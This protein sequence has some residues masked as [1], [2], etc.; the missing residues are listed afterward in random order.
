[1]YR[2]NTGD[3]SGSYF[4]RPLRAKA[5]VGA[6]TRFFD[7]L[8]VWLDRTR[9][10]KLLVSPAGSGTPQSHGGLASRYH[11]GRRA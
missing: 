9:Q 2:Y 11:A 4:V 10:G 5:G 6:T 7:M 1:M 8:M 3:K